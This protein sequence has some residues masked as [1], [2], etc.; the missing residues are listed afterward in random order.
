M[1]LICAYCIVVTKMTAAEAFHPFKK[2]AHSLELFRDITA[3]ASTLDVF[4]C[5][6][7]LEA[8]CKLGW[9]HVPTFDVDFYEHYEKVGLPV[10]R[11]GGRWGSTVA[12]LLQWISVPHFSWPSVRL[13]KGVW[14][15]ISEIGAYFARF[16]HLVRVVL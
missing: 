10:F 8:A 7:A 6:Q 14:C 16:R 2:I 1:F 9:Y 13:G 5:L 3:G 15:R 12:P 11:E 4:T